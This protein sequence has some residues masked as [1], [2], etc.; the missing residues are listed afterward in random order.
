MRRIAPAL[1]IAVLA[2]CNDELAWSLPNE[3]LALQRQGRS[4]TISP[5]SPQFK[6]LS[7]W[8]SRNGTE[9]SSSPASYAPGIVVR[10]S[11]FTINFL[12]SVV[13]VNHPGGQF[14]HKVSPGE[15][16]FLSCPS[17]I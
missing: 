6:D 10:G 2:G 12:D 3:S 16:S 5:D 7:V 9:W 1:L 14:T 4:C 11:N 15:F 13:I 17:G 8:I